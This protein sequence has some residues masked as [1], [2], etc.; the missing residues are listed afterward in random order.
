MRKTFEIYLG[1]NI[2]KPNKRGEAHVQ[3]VQER[4]RKRDYRNHSFD[5]TGV[6]GIIPHIL[7][8][9]VKPAGVFDLSFVANAVLGI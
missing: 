3:A 2:S 9:A 6:G 4:G 8:G 7:Y 1:Y 5:H